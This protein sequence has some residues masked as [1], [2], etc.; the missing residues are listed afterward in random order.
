M[1]TVLFLQPSPGSGLN[2]VDFFIGIPSLLIILPAL[3]IRYR[4]NRGQLLVAA[5]LVLYLFFA[6][7]SM[8]WAE[9]PDLS[10]GFRATGQI[11]ALFSF[12]SYLYLSGQ[13]QL[14][15]RALFIACVATSIICL[16]H[17]ISAYSILSIPLGTPL[18]YGAAESKF[19]AI[20]VKPVNAMLATL[21][22]APQAALLLGLLIGEKSTIWRLA[23]LISLAVLLC[24]LFALERRT[25]QI[26][27]FAILLTCA[28]LYRNRL[29]YLFLAAFGFGT[30][31]MLYFSPEFITSRG[32]SWRPDIWMTT[33]EHIINR[34]LFGHGIS[35]N[36]VPVVVTNEEG[37]TVGIFRHPHNMALSVAYFLGLTGLLLWAAIW[38]PGLIVKISNTVSAR[39]DAFIILPLIAGNAALIFDGGDALSPFHFY[40][41]CFWL[42][43]LLLL[44]SWIANLGNQ[45]TAE[46]EL[47]Q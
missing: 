11:I 8:T 17:L 44:S 2:L 41:F 28:V 40:W 38:I 20:G 15:K 37:R 6:L 1:F 9:K 34:P 45:R 12:F 14:L 23:G 25:G 5:P 18:Y 46:G 7:L 4:L 35:N 26:T 21:I 32:F 13:E 47:T 42:P 22:V 3:L 10:K 16:W 36:I 31:L 43:A 24:Y 30:L 33:I 39:R 19:E 29:W 27:V